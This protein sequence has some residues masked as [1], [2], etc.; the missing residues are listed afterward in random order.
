LVILP[1][2]G[3]VSS[4]HVEKNAGLLGA[5]L[6]PTQTLSSQGEILKHLPGEGVPSPSPLQSRSC[7]F[8]FCIISKFYVKVEK[9]KIPLE[10]L[11]GQSSRIAAET[12]TLFSDTFSLTTV[13]YCLF[14]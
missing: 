8:R 1:A 5:F 2:G 12:H 3:L 4:D 7:F 6:Y 13:N 14:R 10:K 9:A 11:N